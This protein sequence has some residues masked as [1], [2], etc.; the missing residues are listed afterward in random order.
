[1]CVC[2]FECCDMATHKN[3]DHLLAQN[4]KTFI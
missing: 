2:V 3:D 1:M 4:Y